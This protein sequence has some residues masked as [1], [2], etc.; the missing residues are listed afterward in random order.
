MIRHAS[1]TL[2]LLEKTTAPAQLKKAMSGIRTKK[3]WRAIVEEEWNRR[4]P[5]ATLLNRP[6]P[7][8]V[9]SKE[10][11]LWATRRIEE[12]HRRVLIKFLIGKFPIPRRGVRVPREPVR[13]LAMLIK[14]DSKWSKEEEEE[15]IRIIGVLRECTNQH[16]GRRGANCSN[17]H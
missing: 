11:A 8:A 7:K 5:K 17:P 3:E 1:R 6:M 10:P 16:M 13:R 4:P 14:R 2:W 9:W 12:E 15:V